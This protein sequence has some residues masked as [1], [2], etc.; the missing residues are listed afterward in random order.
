[1]IDS[2][3]QI[4]YQQFAD[5]LDYERLMGQNFKEDNNLKEIY[6]REKEYYEKKYK[7]SSYEK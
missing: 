1:M 4:T 6:E 3:R 2:R 7:V 5:S